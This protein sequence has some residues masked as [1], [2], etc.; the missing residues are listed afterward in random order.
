MSGEGFLS[1]W[2]RQK[3]AAEDEREAEAPPDAPVPVA[4][5]PVTPAQDLAPGPADVP[6]GAPPPAPDAEPEFDPASLPPLDSLSAE[7]D[8][9]AFLRKGVPEPLRRAALRKAW[10]LD[11]AIRDFV[12][13]AD[14]DWDFNAPD[15][16][17][18][19][20]LELSGDVQRM[21]AQAVGLDRFDPP[22]AKAE[23]GAPAAPTPDEAGPGEAEDLPG[24]PVPDG[25]AI[26]A[27]PEAAEVAEPMAAPARRHGSAL[28]S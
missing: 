24:E 7:S 13:L 16:V 21:L 14:Y 2:S 11:P 9:G 25:P 3:R 22:E 4:V 17:P 20:A 1:R 18:G 15:G 5:R 23:T 12:G 19:F 6:A 8:F 10:G 26:A 28:P 27:A